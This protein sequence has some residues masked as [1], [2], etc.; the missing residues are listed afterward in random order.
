M[1]GFKSTYKAIFP[2]PV[3]IPE[4]GVVLQPVTLAHIGAL[5]VLGADIFNGDFSPSGVIIA[6]WLLAT[7]TADE[8]QKLFALPNAAQKAREGAAKWGAAFDIGAL[9]LLRG[10]VIKAIGAAFATA[11]KTAN[12]PAAATDGTSDGRLNSPSPLPQEDGAGNT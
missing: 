11:V 1:Q 6:A 4:L 3:E 5:D 7:K 9:A 2:E 10:G 12:P 8:V